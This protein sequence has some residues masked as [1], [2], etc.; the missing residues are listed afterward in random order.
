MNSASN[1]ASG[2]VSV[3]LEPA[4][5]EVAVIPAGG[6]FGEMSLLTGEPRTA[7]VLARED[8]VV[9]EIDAAQF[10]RLGDIDANAVE[11]IGLAAITRRNELDATRSAAAQGTA[12]ADPPSTFL[13]RMRKFLHL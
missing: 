6:Y 3:V 11:R 12:V 2:A 9:M 5:Q 10:R 7:T 13:A 1:W 8:V 4:R